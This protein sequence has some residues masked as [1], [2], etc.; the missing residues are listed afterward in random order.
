MLIQ[1]FSMGM[2]S[3]E[4]IVRL[5]EISATLYKCTFRRVHHIVACRDFHQF[6]ED[7]IN[8]SKYRNLQPHKVSKLQNTCLINN[9]N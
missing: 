1:P 3:S 8:G 5:I 7:L 2:Y 9:L 6:Y 4:I